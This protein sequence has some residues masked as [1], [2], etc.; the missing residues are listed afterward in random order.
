MTV[1]LF[2]LMALFVV[3]FFKIY[4]ILT[5]K[6][7]AY[8]CHESLRYITLGSIYY[9]VISQLNSLTSPHF[10]IHLNV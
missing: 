3:F 5:F 8:Q 4:S 7:R 6:K 1:I 2:I 10:Y 9:N